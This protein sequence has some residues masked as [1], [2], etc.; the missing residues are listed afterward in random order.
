[1]GGDRRSP[2]R[3]DRGVSG[4][5]LQL[6][7][8]RAAQPLREPAG[9]PDLRRLARS[10][11]RR[12]DRHDPPRRSGTGRGDLRGERRDRTHDGRRVPG[13]PARRPRR[14]DPRRGELR[15]LRRG[16]QAAPGPRRDV[17]HHRPARGRRAGGRG[18]GTA[19]RGGGALA[20]ALG[21]P[22]GR[23]VHD[24]LHARPCGRRSLGGPRDRDA[25]RLFARGVAARHH[26]LGADPASG[27]SRRRHRHLGGHG[28]ARQAVRHGVPD[29]PSRRARRV[30]PRP[31]GVR[32]A[33]RPLLRGGRV[34]RRHGAPARR[35]R[36]RPGRGPV[37]HARRT[38][39]GDH[40]HRGAGDRTVRVHQ[41]AGRAGVRLRRRRMDGRPADVGGADPPGRSRARARPER[42]RRRRVERRLPVDH[43]RRPRDLGAQRGRPAP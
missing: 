21:A 43:P 11:R 6:G 14:V 35:A 9:G 17:R 7:S 12:L 34:P 8:E 23:R 37:P 20:D 22:A 28:R 38:T 1:M 40:V 42:H 41:P 30:G 27:G 29:D 24:R 10:V 4:R 15:R 3:A 32:D 18:R 39:A 33:R 19:P 26:H 13:G 25:D 5:L 36:A 31:G 16:R 2:P